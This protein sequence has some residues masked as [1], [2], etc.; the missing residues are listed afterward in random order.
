MPS[1]T[2]SSTLATTGPAA[3][4]TIIPYHYHIT[5]TI[6]PL[7]H[8]GY[9]IQLPKQASSARRHSASD[10][11]GA[12]T[13]DLLFKLPPLPPQPSPPLSP[14][15]PLRGSQ[16]TSPPSPCYHHQHQHQHYYS[17]TTT[18]TTTHPLKMQVMRGCGFVSLEKVF[19]HAVCA[20]QHNT[21]R[22]GAGFEACWSEVQMR[23]FAL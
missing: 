23:Y 17:T 22:P 14:P 2:A 13:K 5:T 19:V 8:H 18:T 10:E 15:P 21:E 1:P 7:S 6:I 3:T 12:Y 16:S 4:T 20:Q 9:L 11:E